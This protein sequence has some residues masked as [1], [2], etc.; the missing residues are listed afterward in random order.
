MK[1]YRVLITRLQLKEEI[2]SCFGIAGA[3]ALYSFVLTWLTYYFI[4]LLNHPTALL[5]PIAGIIML[6]FSLLLS[7]LTTL[8]NIPFFGPA[9]FKNG[10]QRYYFLASALG[11]AITMVLLFYP[12]QA[13]QFSSAN[14]WNFLGNIFYF[15]LLGTMFFLCITHYLLHFT[16]FKIQQKHARQVEDKKIACQFPLALCFG[17]GIG[18]I[19]YPA[20]INYFPTKNL[21]WLISTISFTLMLIPSFTIM[22]PT[23]FQIFT[24]HISNATLIKIVGRNRLFVLRQLGFQGFIFGITLIALCIPFYP[25]GIA[26]Q[27]VDFLVHLLLPYSGALLLG[28]LLSHFFSIFAR[29]MA[30]T[31]MLVLLIIAILGGFFFSP[32]NWSFMPIDPLTALFTMA[33]FGSTGI[34]VFYKIFL[35]SH[36]TGTEVDFS[37]DTAKTIHGFCLDI[38][39][40][41]IYCFWVCPG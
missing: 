11:A 14:A 32:G 41:V 10:R 7:S 33:G 22:H 27:K 40:G 16:T 38:G 35:S 31:I 15:L 39:D 34:F 30:G 4:S 26:G 1:I 13:F 8:S 17:S 37:D 21:V 28:L 5:I 29:I 36:F 6:P 19:A 24:A 20:L 2:V 3:T 25:E 9:N 18:I 23:N 12:P